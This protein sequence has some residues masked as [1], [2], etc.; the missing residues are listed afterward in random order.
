[1]WDS[2]LHSGPVSLGTL[3]LRND[4]DVRMDGHFLSFESPV[5]WLGKKP[6]RT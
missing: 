1:M 2:L 4:D 6:A 5:D 3:C